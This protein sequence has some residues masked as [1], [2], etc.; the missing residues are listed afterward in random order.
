MRE[1][2]NLKN[3]KKLLNLK[4]RI[5]KNTVIFLFSLFAGYSASAGGYEVGDKATDFKLKNVDGSYVSLEDY[6]GAKGF[7]VIFT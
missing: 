5:M 1:L 6:P 2:L 3:W 4:S 7:I